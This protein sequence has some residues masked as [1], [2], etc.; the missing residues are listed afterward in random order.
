MGVSIDPPQLIIF[1]YFYNTDFVYYIA[2]LSFSIQKFF[3]VVSRQIKRKF[4]MDTN[5][6]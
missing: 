1:I 4:K 5:G 2:L 6:A 3:S